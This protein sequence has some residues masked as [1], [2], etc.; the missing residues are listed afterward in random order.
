MKSPFNSML[1]NSDNS[2]IKMTTIYR[3]NKS[4]IGMASFQMTQ[5]QARQ[6]T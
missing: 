5:R 1:N 3:A 6:S 2:M 4:C